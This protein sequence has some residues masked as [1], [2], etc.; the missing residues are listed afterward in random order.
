MGMTLVHR[1]SDRLSNSESGD[2][3]LN[4]VSEVQS[5]SSHTVDKTSNKYHLL[6]PTAYQLASLAKNSRAATPEAE[7]WVAPEFVSRNLRRRLGPK[8]IEE[9]VVRYSAGEHTPALA[10]EYGISTTGL[11]QLLREEGVEFRLQSITQVDSDRAVKLYE[12]GLTIREVATGI[13]YSFGAIRRELH[14]RRVPMRP[15]GRWNH[16]PPKL[17]ADSDQ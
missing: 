6:P 16:L 2:A 7:S 12:S 9:L 15:S 13:G 17:R 10:R 5:L 4:T 11:R 1:V 14:R 3:D 8:I